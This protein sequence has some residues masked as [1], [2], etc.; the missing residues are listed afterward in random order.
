[1]T[2]IALSQSAV[3]KIEN[4]LIVPLAVVVSLIVAYW[5]MVIDRIPPIELSEG[6][7]IPP[8]VKGGE[9]ITAR[10]RIETY[11]NASYSQQCTREIVD[12]LNTFRRV[13]EQE[14]A[15][16]MPPMENYIARSVFVPFDTAWGKAHYRQQCCYQVEGI[17]LTGLFPI[18]VR[19]PELPF[20]ILPNK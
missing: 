6:E 16:V 17:S 2:M 12:S 15:G 5:A 19:R 18:C 14:R 4:W 11:R 10:W 13:D 20:E 8:R 1:M 7:I 9:P 3:R